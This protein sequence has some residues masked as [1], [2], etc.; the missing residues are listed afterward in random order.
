MRAESR[1]RTP[2]ACCLSCCRVLAGESVEG[3]RIP[4]WYGTGCLGL[5]KDRLT[6]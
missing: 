2:P 4:H 3:A 6:W 1:C 5:G